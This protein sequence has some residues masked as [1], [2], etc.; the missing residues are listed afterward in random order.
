MEDLM[1]LGKQS[2]DIEAAW[3]EDCGACQEHRGALQGLTNDVEPAGGAFQVQEHLG[4]GQPA[5]LL[6]EE[7]CQE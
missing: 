4:G 3:R 7:V 5:H 1:I 6:A 2:L